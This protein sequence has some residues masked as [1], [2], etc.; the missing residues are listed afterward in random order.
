MSESLLAIDVTATPPRKPPIA[1][2][3]SMPIRSA[4]IEVGDVLEVGFPENVL[5]D[6][7]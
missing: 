7:S 1:A 3:G 6:H 4:D 2:P 5:L